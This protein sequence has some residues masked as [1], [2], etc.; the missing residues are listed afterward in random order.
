MF[1]GIL[2]LKESNS[3][4]SSQII[5]F[6]HMQEVEQQ[7]VSQDGQ[8]IIIRMGQTDIIGTRRLNGVKGGMNGIFLFTLIPTFSHMRTVNP[9]FIIIEP[10]QLILP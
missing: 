3:S 7:L 2:G 1:L 5:K 9:R 4:K 10:G 6:L 8:N